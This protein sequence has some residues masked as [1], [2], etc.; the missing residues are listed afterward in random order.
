[1]GLVIRHPDC[2]AVMSA[3]V[4]VCSRSSNFQ[5]LV[6]VYRNV[7]RVKRRQGQTA[8]MRSVDNLCIPVAGSEASWHECERR[9]SV[10]D[11]VTNE[12][13]WIINVQVA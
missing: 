10:V 3:T 2:K 8:F 4:A 13:S 5:S 12:S 1:M 9:G 6:E 11:N 7:G